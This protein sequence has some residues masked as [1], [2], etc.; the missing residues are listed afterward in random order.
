M[1]AKEFLKYVYWSRFAKPVADREVYRWVHEN[2]PRAI[3]EMGLGQAVRTQR[4]FEILTQEIPAAEIRYAGIDLFE[5]R[6]AASSG[7][8]LKQVHSL[9]KPTGVKIQLI[10]GDPYSA[11]AR[12]ANGLAKTD[13]LLISADQDPESLARAWTYVPRMLTASSRVLLE[14]NVKGQM[15]FVPLTLADVEQRAAQA[16]SVRRAA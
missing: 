10:P 13:L 15:A 11:L 1:S 14:S 5:L 7:L 8:P 9:L 3:V 12:A 6:S 4:M 2:R 16:K